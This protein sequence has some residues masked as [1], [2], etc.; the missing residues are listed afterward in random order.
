MESENLL[1]EMCY[2]NV[3][4]A[5]YSKIFISRNAPYDKTKPHNRTL[6]SLQAPLERL[7]YFLAGTFLSHFC[8]FVLFS[9][10]MQAKGVMENSRRKSLNEDTAGQ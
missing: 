2:S 6:F 4:E 3:F 5:E 8:Y 1:T 9:L 10:P 7:K